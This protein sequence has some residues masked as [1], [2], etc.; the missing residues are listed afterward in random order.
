MTSATT[1]PASLDEAGG[2]HLL[3]I[4]K[5]DI[6][7]SHAILESLRNNAFIDDSTRLVVTSINA[8]NPHLQL[9]TSILVRAEFITTGA[10]DV[11]VAVESAHLHPKFPTFPPSVLFSVFLA[12][13]GVAIMMRRIL[14]EKRSRRCSSFTT[15]QEWVKWSIEM[16]FTHGVFIVILALVPYSSS[17]RDQIGSL[18][19]LGRTPN[20]SVYIDLR[21]VILQFRFMMDWLSIVSILLW[22]EPFQIMK[23]A[24]R[25]GPMV[26]AVTD[27][28]TSHDVLLYI[29]IFAF[30]LLLFSMSFQIAYGTELDQFTRI[31]TAIF[32]LFKMPFAEEWQNLDTPKARWLTTIYWMIFLILSVLLLNLLIAIVTQVYP[33]KLELS[34]AVWTATITENMQLQL[35]LEERKRK[36]QDTS[37]DSGGNGGSG[38]GHNEDSEE[39]KITLAECLNKQLIL[40][41]FDGYN[42]WRGN[43]KMVEDETS[44][45]QEDHVFGVGDQDDSL[46][47]LDNVG[48][49]ES[50][51]AGLASGNG[52]RTSLIQLMTALR[53]S[54][55]VS[56]DA[57]QKMENALKDQQEKFTMM[58][59][60]MKAL[61]DTLEGV[62]EMARETLTNSNNLLRVTQVNQRT[63]KR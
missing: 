16:F 28:I 26:V 60:K 21:N 47:L 63:G 34:D 19:L 7:S 35:R 48:D 31:D 54:G 10:V 37:G 45:D 59:A 41:G 40:E 27:T 9:F 51:L 36:S 23:Q 56:G 50:L 18:N 8:Y 29:F 53:G 24:P 5:G 4:N 43:N 14:A 49:G 3:P 52:G 25:I 57:W 33:E 62:V 2:G 6:K 11:T 46:S 1:H 15:T 42:F 30:F 22:F 55:N 39:N 61:D 20:S 13:G 38:G 12:I 58:Q 32:A 17:L 44:T